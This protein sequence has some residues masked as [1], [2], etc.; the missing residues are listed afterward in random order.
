MTLR[1]RSICYSECSPVP[2]REPFLVN[3]VLYDLFLDPD[4]LDGVNAPGGKGVVA[5]GH[6]A[7]AEAAAAVL[8]ENGHA[9]DA[10]IAGLAMACFCEPVLASPGGV[11]FAMI[12]QADGAVELIDFFAQTPKLRRQRSI[13]GFFEIFA[14][15]GTATQ[16]FHIGPATSATPGFFAGIRKMHARGGGVSLADLFAPACHAARIGIA[17]SPFQ[18]YLATVVRPILTA[19][20]A[21]AALFAPGG[22]LHPVGHEFR[23]PDLADALGVLANADTANNA[24]YEQIVD[25]QAKGGHLTAADLEGYEAIIRKPLHLRA[26]EATI[27]LNPLP[28]AGGPLIAHSLGSLERTGAEAMAR[29][30][31][32][33]GKARSAANGNLGQLAR[34]PLRQRGT[35]HISVIDGNRNACAITVSNGEGN[36]SLIGD[37]GFMLNNVLG[38]EDV[39][40][41][42]AQDWPPDTRLA[43]MMCPTIVEMDDG[44]IVAL[45]SGGSNRIRSAIFQVIVRHCLEKLDIEQ[46]VSAPRLHVEGD[47]LDFEEQF[48]DAERRALR[49]AFADHRGWPRP[50]LFFGGV[51]AA[52]VDRNGRFHGTGDSRR[53]GYAIVVD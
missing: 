31:W 51:H 5:A 25:D 4:G 29:T 42:L 18:Y 53:D 16:A 26:G 45:G 47:H 10:A 46:A 40:P 13:A 9:V 3:G 27:H 28:A 39:N 48:S 1:R 37:F 23:N 34:A 12:R 52:C 32:Q 7:T 6:R 44:G 43:S 36:G 33:T 21:A 30:L 24:V 17:I 38:E 22:E 50:N 49:K 14:D 15:F 11:G 19:T 8:R 41:V 20:P 35:T 2:Q